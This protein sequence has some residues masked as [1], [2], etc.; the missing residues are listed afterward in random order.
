VTSG[1]VLDR[2][3]LVPI[4]CERLATGKES[5]TAI[6]ADL[7][8]SRRTFNAWRREDKEIDAV[9]V[10]ARQDWCEAIEDDIIDIAD[11][12]C[13]GVEIVERAG[14]KEVHI[15][16]MLGHRKLRI[17]ARE[18]LLRAHNPKRWGDRLVTEN[19]NH[20]TIEIVDTDEMDRRLDRAVAAACAAAGVVEP[21][22]TGT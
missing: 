16:D 5:L 11:T 8:F 15:G 21:V 22:S 12:T 7:G 13:E 20:T 18:R 2:A 17:Y 1:V 6:C 4:V 10:I 19:T 9:A 3:A 14:K